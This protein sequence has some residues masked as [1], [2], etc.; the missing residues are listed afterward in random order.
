MHSNY[1]FFGIFLLI[2]LSVLF[3]SHYFVYYSII[4]F[5]RVT[6][7]N[8]KFILASALC[9][10]P[11][12]FFIASFLSRLWENL[13]TRIFYFFS[14]LWLG[15]LAT[16][17]VAFA[18]GWLIVGIVKISGNTA[19]TKTLGTIIF[20]LVFIY[21]GY[22]VWNAYH[23]KIKNVTFKINNLPEKWKSKTAVQISDVHLGHILQANFM[24]GIVEK[25]NFKNPD[26]VF[27]T[28]D[29]FDGMD[30]N[31]PEIAK[32]LKDIKAS[33]GMYYVTG[34][35]ETYLG[36]ARAFTAVKDT[37]IK[38]L[39]DQMDTV[40]EMQ[41]VGISYPERGQSKNVEEILKNMP[42]F[43]PSMP[44]ILLFH[45]PTQMDRAKKEGISLQLS[46]HTHEGQIFPLRL[47]TWLIW[48]GYDYGL[49]TDGNFSLYTSSGVGVWGPTMRTGNTPEI[50]VIKFE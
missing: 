4:S 21:S 45:S 31:L 28:G 12:S 27:I 47:V 22:G 16:L 6:S 11:L 1:L 29:L 50:V 19:N 46:G 32:P 42:G 33:D 36:V 10:L 5:W 8:A 40:G 18:L 38:I 23:P 15:I 14:G 35:H 25:I 7:F 17:V 43:K 34:N 37:G 39:D 48:K 44:S 26:I 9:A 24:K 2:A 20:A 3:G 30:G 49:Y 13:F 41:I